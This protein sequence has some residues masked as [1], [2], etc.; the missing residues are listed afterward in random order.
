MQQILI[1][2]LMTEKSWRK[3]KRIFNCFKDF[4]KAFDKIKHDMIWNVL[5]SFG[6]DIKITRLLQNIYANSK[7]AV[8]VGRELG[9]WFG[10]SIETRQGDPV[11]SA[12]FITYLERAMDACEDC[13]TGVNISG[14]LIDNLRFADD[15]D[16]LEE[17]SED[18][19]ESLNGVAAAAEPMGLRLNIA[20]TKV[21]IFG[22]EPNK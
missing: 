21:M 19:Q 5:N 15:I 11:S 4:Q 9:D 6:V 22:E 12:I 2:R 17:R 13:R 14:E 3:D 7:A 18:L 20:K 1:L 16:L 8:Q 10:Q